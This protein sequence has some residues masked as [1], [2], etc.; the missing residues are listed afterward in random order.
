MRC[1]YGS[2][3]LK[4]CVSFDGHKAILR[5]SHDFLAIRKTVAELTCERLTKSR[6][7]FGRTLH[8]TYL[9]CNTML[10]LPCAFL[11]VCDFSG[12]WLR[13]TTVRKS[14]D[15]KNRTSWCEQDLRD[16]SLQTH[17]HCSKVQLWLPCSFFCRQDK[18]DK[19]SIKWSKNREKMDS[20][21]CVYLVYNIQLN[22]EIKLVWTIGIVCIV[23][24]LKKIYHFTY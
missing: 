22:S 11:D 14:Y 20:C 15:K 8:G 9:C 23:N 6:T 3:F 2:S 1:S 17:F 5:M 12:I 10:H 21:C 16:L 19:N 24:F 4:S 18:K 7:V 13:L